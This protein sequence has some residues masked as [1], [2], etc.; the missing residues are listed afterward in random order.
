MQG[1]LGNVASRLLAPCTKG[2]SWGASRVERRSYH[3]SV[4]TIIVG[5][6]IKRFPK[7]ESCFPSLGKDDLLRY[8]C[9]FFKILVGNF[10]TIFLSGVAL[11]VL[12]LSGSRVRGITEY[13]GNHLFLF[14]GIVYATD[15]RYPL[16]MSSMPAKA[17]W[18]CFLVC[19]VF[20]FVSMCSPTGG[21]GD[22]RRW[23]GWVASPTQ[24][25]WVWIN[26][27]SWW[28]TGRGLACCS[29]RGCKES[30]MTERLN[31]TEL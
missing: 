25:T 14:C 20:C 6:G 28:W 2:M 3:F 21:E 10:H 5:N 30:D 26:S 9:I 4:L 31:W 18:A 16:K 23:D 7:F 24:W 17:V 11:S 15:I 12:L 1:S 27:R 22:D 19:F 8:C 29:P 13:T